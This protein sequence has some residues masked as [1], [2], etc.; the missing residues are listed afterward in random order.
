M[1]ASA[2]A[3]RVC[4]KFY[5]NYISFNELHKN[6]KRATPNQFMLYKLAICLFKLYSVE[7][8]IEFVLL[9]MKKIWTGR[10]TYFNSIKSNHFKVGINSLSNRLNELN[11][12]IPLAWLNLSLNSFKIKCKPLFLINWSNN[13][14]QRPPIWGSARKFTCLF[15]I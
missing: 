6:F 13:Y 3:L 8:N 15:N 10:Q 2:K 5:D 7:Y 14:W 4:S 11:N 1:S 12:K 9:N